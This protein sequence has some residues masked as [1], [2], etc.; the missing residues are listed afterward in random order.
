MNPVQWFG[1]FASVWE[2]GSAAAAPEAAG[3]AVAVGLGV[4]AMAVAARGASC[5]SQGACTAAWR[6]TWHPSYIHLEA[7]RS[8]QLE[9]GTLGMMDH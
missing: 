3:S 9:P 6:Y 5:T 1:G 7:Q 4:V 8:R 2:A